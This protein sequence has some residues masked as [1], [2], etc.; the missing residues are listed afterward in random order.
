MQE[1]KLISTIE[2][3]KS[4]GQTEAIATLAKDLK[5]AYDFA[6]EVLGVTKIK[7]EIPTLK[8]ADRGR[9][10]DPYIDILEKKFSKYSTDWNFKNKFQYILK[11]ENRFLHFREVA[12]II[13]TLE[14]ED[15]SYESQR[16]LARKLGGNTLIRNLNKEGL[17]VNV[18]HQNS[19]KKSFWG[20]S[21]W[22]N[23]DGD[24][25]PEHK[26]SLAITKEKEKGEKPKGNKE[27]D[28]F[29]I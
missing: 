13:L 23:A 14:G 20:S 25:L 3:L 21:K 16:I 27:K 9:S 29:N 4:F 18:L 8:E 5:E 11:I 19:P 10:N 17:I 24:I 6:I 7:E 2:T 1:N 22:L 12:K 26:Y 15:T 28:L